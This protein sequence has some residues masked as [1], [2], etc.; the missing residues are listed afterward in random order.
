MPFIVQVRDLKTAMPMPGMRLGDM[1]G[2]LASDCGRALATRYLCPLTLGRC[3]GCHATWLARFVPS[4]CFWAPCW[5]DLAAPKASSCAANRRFRCTGLVFRQCSLACFDLGALRAP[6]RPGWLNW[7]AL[8]TPGRP[9]LAGLLWLS[10]VLLGALSGSIWLPCTL[11]GAL[12]GSIWLPSALLGVLAGS[13]WL[14]WSLLG[15]LTASIW[16]P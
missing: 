14:L 15:A 12:A 3:M 13:I 2:S 10:C 7:A 4:V 6:G 9:P 1:G 11:L 8:C 16:L 5:I